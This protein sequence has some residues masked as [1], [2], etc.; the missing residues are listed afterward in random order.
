MCFSAWS[1]RFH[2][3]SMGTTIAEYYKCSG[4]IYNAVIIDVEK[5]AD[6]S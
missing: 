5:I 2:K 4:E 1:G 3:L 6:E